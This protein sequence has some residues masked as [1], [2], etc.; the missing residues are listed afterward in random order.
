MLH[1]RLSLAIICLCLVGCIS[2]PVAAKSDKGEKYLGSATATLFSG[3]F[4]ATSL[5]GVH[6]TGTYNPWIT[7]PDLPITFKL[8]DGRTGHA[9]VLRDRTGASGMGSGQTS[10]GTKYDFW[11]GNAIPEQ[12]KTTW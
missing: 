12:I 11:M 7:S 10:D 3:S 1:L 6:L 9:I 8:S 2:V 5:S 4:E